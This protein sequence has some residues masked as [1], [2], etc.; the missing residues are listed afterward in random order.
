VNFEAPIPANRSVDGWKDVEIKENGEPLVLLNNYAP[1][2]I[3]VL[4]Q[5]YLQGLSNSINECFCREG[6]ATRLLTAAKAMPAGYK[7][8]IWDAW[9]PIEVQNELFEIY[10]GKLEQDTE[11]TG[12]ALINEA[13]KY[14]SLP[15]TDQTK[16]SPHL[17]GG[18]IDLTMIDAN[19][20][21]LDMGTEFDHFGPEAQTDYFETKPNPSKKDISIK[22]NRRFLYNLLTA[23]GF[24][25]YP[26]EWWHFDYGNQFWAVQTG[27]EAIYNQTT[28]PSQ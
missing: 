19:G 12:E 8:L 28:A 26:H 4:Q 3:T 25:N 18:A 10:K 27:R 23:A 20:Q 22:K 17:T 15:S 1:D 7:L 16:P 2:H 13:Q 24:T 5:Y 14:I 21:R 9:R 6:L 11:L